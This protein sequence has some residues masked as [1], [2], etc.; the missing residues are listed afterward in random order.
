MTCA[1]TFHRV[2]ALAASRRTAQAAWRSVIE[3]SPRLPSGFPETLRHRVGLLCVSGRAHAGDG[4][5]P[6]DSPSSRMMVIHGR[7][8]S[9]HLS[10]MRDVARTPLRDRVGNV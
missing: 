7:V 4:A 3:C 10:A 6:T 1:I 9:R 8:V 2:Q 5:L